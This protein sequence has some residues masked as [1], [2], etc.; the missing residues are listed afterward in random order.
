MSS[1]QSGCPMMAGS[2]GTHNG[3]SDTLTT[4]RPVSTGIASQELGNLDFWGGPILCANCVPTAPKSV[5]IPAIAHY[6]IGLVPLRTPA[7]EESQKSL[8]A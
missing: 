8:Q 4:V 7:I 6:H 3:R 2:G 1:G 5:E